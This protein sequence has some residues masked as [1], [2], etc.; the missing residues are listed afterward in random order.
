MT[1]FLLQIGCTRIS[2]DDQK[3]D[4]RE[5]SNK[6]GQSFPSENI[7][8]APLALTRG[9]CSCGN[10]M[11]R[12]LLEPLFQKNSCFICCAFHCFSL[13]YSNTIYLFSI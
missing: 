10:D 12:K 5:R 1:A 9:F 4:R 2:I 7:W 13:S 6:H 8:S 3:L 11:G